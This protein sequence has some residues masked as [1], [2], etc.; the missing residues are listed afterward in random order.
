MKTTKLLFFCAMALLF[1]ACEGGNVN[2]RKISIEG[3]SSDDGTSQQDGGGS[4]S[5]SAIETGKFF[6]VEA[7]TIEYTDGSV[8]MFE[9]YGLNFKLHTTVPE[10]LFIYNGTTLWECDVNSMSYEEY[11]EPENSH[12][13]GYGALAEYLFTSEMEA[14]LKISP[15]V[16]RS[17]QTIAGISCTVYRDGEDGDAYAGHKGIIFLLGDDLIASSYAETCDAEFVVPEGYTKIEY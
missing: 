6:D 14:V 15:Y 13:A 17:T 10:N 4:S 9:N 12:A 7:A 2:D 16:V 1:A 5:Q 11:S 8:L 3:D